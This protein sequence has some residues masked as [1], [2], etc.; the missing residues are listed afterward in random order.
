[1]RVSL[2]VAC[3]SA[4]GRVVEKSALAP[5]WEIQETVCNENQDANGQNQDAQHLIALPH[6]IGLENKEK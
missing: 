6:G 1:V 4:L 5:N 3:K 2:K